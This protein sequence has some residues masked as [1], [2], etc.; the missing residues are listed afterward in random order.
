MS[1]ERLPGHAEEHQQTDSPVSTRPGFRM[2]C[3]LAAKSWNLFR[4]DLET[5]ILQIHLVQEV[6]GWN[7]QFVQSCSAVLF[8]PLVFHKCSCGTTANTFPQCLRGDSQDH[9]P[10]SLVFNNFSIE[11][12]NAYCRFRKARAAFITGD[13][14]VAEFARY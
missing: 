12:T 9:P 14:K 8:P 5:Y 2:S 13:G 4:T 11:T 6:A 7:P 3:H 1:V 10:L